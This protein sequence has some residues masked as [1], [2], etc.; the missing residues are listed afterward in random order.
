LWDYVRRIAGHVREQALL[1]Y[2]KK[3]EDDVVSAALEN[4]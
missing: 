1:S 4:T 2:A 3:R